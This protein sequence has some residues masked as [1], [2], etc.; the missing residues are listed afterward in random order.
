MCASAYT[1]IE[2]NNSV[3]RKVESSSRKLPLIL[4]NLNHNPLVPIVSN[5]ESRQTVQ[6]KAS[7]Q[8]L[9]ILR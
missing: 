2:N 6:T 9:H 5:V 4:A 3:D 7:D 8:G 1:S